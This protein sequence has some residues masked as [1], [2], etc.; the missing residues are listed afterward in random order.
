M[1]S[2]HDYVNLVRLTSRLERACDDLS[3]P[4]QP[5]QGIHNLLAVSPYCAPLLCVA[6]RAHSYWNKT[7]KYGHALLQ[8]L[9]TSSFA[10]PSYANQHQRGSIPDLAQRLQLVDEKLS[11]VNT[12]CFAILSLY[13]P[14]AHNCYSQ[15]VHRP[16]LRKQLPPHLEALRPPPPP[17]QPEPAQRPQSQKST[18]PATPTQSARD[19][20]L[21]R[22]PTL[23]RQRSGVQSSQKES[24]STST[25]KETA[26]SS[27]LLQ[28]HREVQEGLTQDLAGMAKQLKL[29][30]LHFASNLEKDKALMTTVEDQMSGSKDDMSKNR[31]RL[32]AYEKKGGWTTCFTIMAVAMVCCAWFFMFALS[33]SPP[34]LTFV[35][36]IDM[37]RVPLVNSSHHLEVQQISFINMSFLC[38]N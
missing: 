8:R 21:N 37:L 26:E 30:S 28:H 7:S 22:P 9:Q 25:P 4:G 33:K 15:D 12:V 17:A 5:P 23:F 36:P 35:C 31:T 29:N 20:L 3:S 11:S 1:D 32:G 34:G 18:Q 19:E 38:A 13:R 10:G 6:L 2:S 14:L 24:T 16:Q 27:H